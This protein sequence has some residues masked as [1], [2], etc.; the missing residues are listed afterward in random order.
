[1]P[2]AAYAGNR[3]ESRPIP[4]SPK[5]EDPADIG[6][7]VG[8][9]VSD[10]PRLNLREGRSRIQDRAGALTVPLISIF[11]P[12][13]EQ[14]HFLIFP[15]R[16]S[17]GDNGIYVEESDDRREIKIQVLT[18]VVREETRYGITDHSLPSLDQ[19]AEYPERYREDMELSLITRPAASLAEF[20][21]EF[22]R[23]RKRWDKEALPPPRTPH[24]LCFP[25]QEKK[26]NTSNW[27]EEQGYYS[28][29]MRE[30]FLQ[31]WQIGWTGGMI[32]TYPL[33]SLGSPET[34]KRVWRNI[35]WV[36]RDGISP[37]GFFWDSGEKGTLWYGGDIRREHTRNW[38]LIRK[39][40]DALFYLVKQFRLLEQQGEVLPENWKERLKSVADCFV[41]LWKDEGQLGQFVDS[42]SGEVIVGGST[43]GG[44]VPAAL[45]LAADY[46]EE[47]DYLGTA[48]DIAH[49]FYQHYVSWGI[50][51]GGP[52]DALQCPDSESA[53]AL[54]ESFVTLH[55]S[56]YEGPWLA[57]ARD[58]AHQFSSW[59]M[60]WNYAFPGDSLLG[61]LD[62]CTKGS[63]GANTQNKHGAPGICAHS[64]SALLR[65]SKYTGD[66][67]Y[68]MLLQE[69]CRAIPQFLSRED[70]PV[71]GLEAGWMSERVS[72]TDWFEGIGEI[73]TGSTWAET[74]LML[75]YTELPG[76]YL[77][78]RNHILFAF[79]QLKARLLE[80]GDLEFL[81]HTREEV[82]IRV[83]TDTALPDEALWPV[84]LGAY[85][86]I[87]VLAPGQLK[88][89]KIPDK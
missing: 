45:V 44:I 73:M 70:R 64:G 29:G 80:S 5:L 60:S 10:I 23:L 81:N 32:S 30:N 77:D 38:H 75:S 42:L 9:I 43:S 72:T 21:E 76:Y 68:A 82:S 26:F 53:Y 25:L 20:F 37:S 58:M 67:S 83:L 16:G 12:L 4:Y 69:I 87:L 2:G 3:F 14:S 1:L 71:P 15:T 47:P 48:A 27:V 62:I 51:C 85:C 55:E 66:P 33:L 40:G 49:Y 74:S 88:T 57:R 86:Q 59:V 17:H 24:S 7:D 35:D 39:S 50:S 6:K 89:L 11:D 52:G 61:E 34:R 8:I 22:Y 46:Y 13:E 36:M 56:G 18:P 78:T 63:V 65:L 79:D 28:V 54:L 19:P 31:D 41:R 84:D